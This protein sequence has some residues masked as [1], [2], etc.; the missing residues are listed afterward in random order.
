V[1]RNVLAG[2]QDREHRRFQ[3][4]DLLQEAPRLGAVRDVALERTL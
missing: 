4:R 3:A 2:F 1:R